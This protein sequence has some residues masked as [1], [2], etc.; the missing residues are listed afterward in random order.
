MTNTQWINQCIAIL[1]C[2]GFVYIWVRGL[3]LVTYQFF[4]WVLVKLG[5]ANYE[6]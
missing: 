1:A 2:I 5:A 3:F 6:E 4:G